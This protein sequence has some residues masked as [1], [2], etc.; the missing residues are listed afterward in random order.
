M[1]LALTAILYRPG[2]TVHIFYAVHHT[3]TTASCCATSEYFPTICPI[4]HIGYDA[5][6]RFSIMMCL[7]YSE[8]QMI[9]YRTS[10]Q[11]TRM[12]G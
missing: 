2:F 9:D 12:V 4:P 3:A 1:S 7:A 5:E 10:D 11:K 6:R 8:E